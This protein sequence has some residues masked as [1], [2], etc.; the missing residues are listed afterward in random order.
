M[1][2]HSLKTPH[3]YLTSL[4]CVGSLIQG[5]WWPADHSGTGCSAMTECLF[6]QSPLN[7]KRKNRCCW[8]AIC[9]DSRWQMAASKFSHK[10]LLNTA[11]Y[12]WHRYRNRRGVL[13]I[14]V[15]Q[16]HAHTREHTEAWTH[17]GKSPVWN[18]TEV[19]CLTKYTHHIKLSFIHS[20]DIS[21]GSMF[22]VFFVLFLMY[23]KLL[24]WCSLYCIAVKEGVW[25]LYFYLNVF[26]FFIA[27]R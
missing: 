5:H 17:S 15:S 22:R 6:Y 1:N 19:Q 18:H 2:T 16:L 23:K 11:G 4:M 12:S 21:N 13:Q 9:I 20:S 14:N 24:A 7:A 27:Q 25:I 10:R 26:C 8:L 3:A